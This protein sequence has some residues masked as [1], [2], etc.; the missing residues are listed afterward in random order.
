MEHKGNSKLKF[1]RLQLIFVLLMLIAL[2]QR[3]YLLAVCCGITSTIFY[4]LQ[5]KQ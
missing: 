3:N 2:S 4:I 1:K 5:N